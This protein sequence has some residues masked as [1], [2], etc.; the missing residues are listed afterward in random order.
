[1]SVMRHSEDEPLIPLGHPETG[2]MTEEAIPNLMEVSGL[3]VLGRK[4]RCNL[5][6][7]NE[8]AIIVVNL[9]TE[10]PSVGQGQTAAVIHPRVLD[11]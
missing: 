3:P 6:W 11:L 2:V 9:D 10:L 7:N 5:R 4:P 1:M 8:G